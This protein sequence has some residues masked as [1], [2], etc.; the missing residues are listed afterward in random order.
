MLENHQHCSL[1]LLSAAWP[2]SVGAI[3]C[4]NLFF[5]LK[6]L[7]DADPYIP[8]GGGSQFYINQNNLLVQFA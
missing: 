8:G 5:G 2:S 1:Q 7:S 6:R 3:K 4:L